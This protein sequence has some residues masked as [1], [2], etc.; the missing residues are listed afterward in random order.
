M[1]RN[2]VTAIVTQVL[3]T[4]MNNRNAGDKVNRDE[5]IDILL[6]KSAII[7]IF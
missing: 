3:K 1:I 4:L 5:L 6:G 7:I 2:R